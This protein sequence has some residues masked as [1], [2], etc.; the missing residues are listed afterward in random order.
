MEVAWTRNTK[1]EWYNAYP[2][3]LI[4]LTLSG[5]CVS[6]KTPISGPRRTNLSCHELCLPWK[7][8]CCRASSSS[9]DAP[10][11][12]W[13]PLLNLK[14]AL[15]TSSQTRPG[16]GPWWSDFARLS[17][18]SGHLGQANL[19]LLIKS[20]GTFSTRTSKRP[21]GRGHRNLDTEDS[22][23]DPKS[24]I[25]KETW[26]FQLKFSLLA[27]L[28][29]NLRS[30]KVATRFFPSVCAFVNSGALGEVAE[31]SIKEKTRSRKI[32]GDFG[33]LKEFLCM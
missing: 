2:S 12:W 32:A 21:M 5:S 33:F 15:S 11:R 19:D 13:A 14:M 9:S 18:W 7:D 30:L 24:K 16:H 28:A 29:G 1:M 26:C 3:K 22:I 10:N 17:H 27:A 4:A 31:W 8:R 25:Q 6:R 23:L 20:R